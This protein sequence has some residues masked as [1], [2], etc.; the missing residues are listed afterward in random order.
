MSDLKGL[1][2]LRIEELERENAGLREALEE[3]L[4]FVQRYSNR[5]DAEVDGKHP[6]ST[7][8]K[9]MAALTQAGGVRED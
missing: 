7:V 3:C 9:A 2:N 1:M 4:E 5:W 6:Q 8:D